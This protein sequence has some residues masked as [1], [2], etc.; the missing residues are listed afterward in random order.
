MHIDGEQEKKHFHLAPSFKLI[1]IKKS[2][3]ITTNITFYFNNFRILET[4][5]SII[6]LRPKK[7]TEIRIRTNQEFQRF[8]NK[9]SGSWPNIGISREIGPQSRSG[10]A[11][12]VHLSSSSNETLALLLI[13][14]ACQQ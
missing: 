9:N 7:Q 10:V 14:I 5:E 3:I 6:R 2:I 12:R 4:S 13:A 11:N 1:F 8:R